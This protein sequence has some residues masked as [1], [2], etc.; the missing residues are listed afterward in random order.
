MDAAL[1]FAWGQMGGSVRRVYPVIETATLDELKGR[2]DD[3]D[4]G[5]E[6][7]SM[8]GDD[9]EELVALRIEVGRLRNELWKVKERLFRAP[10]RR[11]LPNGPSRTRP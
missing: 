3:L 11:H 4:A 9:E 1:E 7:D 2:A 8:S 5:E 6:E 10:E